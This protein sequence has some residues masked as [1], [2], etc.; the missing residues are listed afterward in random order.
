M[1]YF[2]FDFCD[3]R[4]VQQYRHKKGYFSPPGF[5][6]GSMVSRHSFLDLGIVVIYLG[7]FQLWVS[8]F[9]GFMILFPYLGSEHF[10]FLFTSLFLSS[11]FFASLPLFR[12]W[13]LFFSLALLVCLSCVSYVCFRFMS[14]VL[15]FVYY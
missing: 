8:C 7:S 15:L 2:V 3:C 12:V 1:D 5:V 14:W 6:F 4:I 11:F 10:S 13:A 9:C